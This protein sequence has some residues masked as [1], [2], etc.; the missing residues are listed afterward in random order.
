MTSTEHLQLNQWVPE[1]RILRQDFNRDNAKLDAAI[2]RLNA[3]LHPTLIREVVTSATA[4]SVELD[5][6]DI[7]W[8]QWNCVIVDALARTESGTSTVT[9]TYYAG[10]VT[11]ELGQIRAAGV[12]A[13]ENE[14]TSRLVLCC[15]KEPQRRVAAVSLAAGVSFY[16]TTYY[17]FRELQSLSCA[18]L[19][20]G[21]YQISAGSVFRIMGVK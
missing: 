18:H 11:R 7:D 17:R 20:S 12:D 4:D 8:S 1:D 15:R 3:E 6:S 14:G 5:V 10:M 13:A 16:Q 2:G 21:G 19:T 9:L